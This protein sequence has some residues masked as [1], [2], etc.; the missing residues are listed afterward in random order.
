[1]FSVIV[2]DV[3]FDVKSSVCL[4]LFIFSIWC[5]CQKFVSAIR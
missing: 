2:L 1:M 5:V 3:W 4:V